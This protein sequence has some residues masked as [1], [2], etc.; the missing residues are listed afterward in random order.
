MSEIKYLE[1]I[2]ALQYQPATTDYYKYGPVEVLGLREHF[3]R[4]IYDG[5]GVDNIFDLTRCSIGEVNAGTTNGH[6]SFRIRKAIQNIGLNIR[7]ED[8]EKFLY[9]YPEYLKEIAD[10]RIKSW[11]LYLFIDATLINLERMRYYRCTDMYKNIPDVYRISDS[12]ECINDFDSYLA[13]AQRALGKYENYINEI[14]KVYNEDMEAAIGLSGK[15]GDAEKIVAASESLMAIYRKIVR[16]KYWLQSRTVSERYKPY[17]EKLINIADDFYS[18][19][20]K[21]YEKLKDARNLLIDLDKGRVRAKG[22]EVDITL[23]TSRE[24]VR[25]FSRSMEELAENKEF[26]KN[27]SELSDDNKKT[28]EREISKFIIK[29]AAEIQE[30]TKKE[31]INELKGHIDSI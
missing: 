9:G 24:A 13:T 4:E 16:W 15:N 23:N 18:D 27:T 5:I 26:Y 30:N 28:V 14:G 11:E 17:I 8:T 7:P 21:Y 20:D 22:T 10:R 6:V 1:D 12:D 29:L 3:N 31:I 2:G 19:M 25:G